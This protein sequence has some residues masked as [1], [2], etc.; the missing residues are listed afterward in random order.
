VPPGARRCCAPSV[1]EHRNHTIRAITRN[2]IFS[3]VSNSLKTQANHSERSEGSRFDRGVW[4][5]HEYSFEKPGF[6]L[7][8]NN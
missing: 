7:N 8:T 4:S 6:I 3:S 1:E 2:S 5:R